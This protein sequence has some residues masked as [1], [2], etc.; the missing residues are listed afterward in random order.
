[1]NIIPL[2]VSFLLVLGISSSFLISQRQA[3]IQEG[4]SYAGRMHTLTAARNQFEEDTYDHLTSPDNKGKTNNPS[5]KP[6]PEKQ[7]FTKKREKTEEE[8]KAFLEKKQRQRT[9]VYSTLNLAYLV[10]HPTSP[11]HQIAEDLIE[12]LYG[13]TT[14]FQDEP[15][16]AHNLLTYILETAKEH[17]TFSTFEELLEKE[18]QFNEALYKM[19]KGTNAFSIEKK[20]GYPPLTDYISFDRNDKHAI[21]LHFASLPLLEQMFGPKVVKEIAEIELKKYKETDTPSN[22]YWITKNELE[23]LLNTPTPPKYSYAVLENGILFSTT[24][25]KNL[26]SRIV[27]KKTKISI[28][29]ALNN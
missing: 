2:V 25:P 4:R 3:T 22:W 26:S 15:A 23:E 20:K 5:P 11:Y 17:P 28:K 19:L 8:I 21:R 18:S 12:A 6:T 27:D 24:K 16:L 1:M 13:H 14:F 9:S 7:E 10:N 29:E